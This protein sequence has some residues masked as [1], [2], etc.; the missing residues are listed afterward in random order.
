M[1]ELEK[2]AAFGA[3]SEGDMADEL[4]KLA[5]LHSDG[6]LSDDEFK[7]LKTRVIAGT[8]TSSNDG[9]KEAKSSDRT[10]ANDFANDT[11]P[12][13]LYETVLERFVGERSLAYYE[14]VFAKLIDAYEIKNVRLSDFD[15]RRLRQI[16]LQRDAKIAWSER[17]PFVK[18]SVWNWSAF[19][20]GIFWAVWRGIAYKWWIFA[21]VIVAVVIFDILGSYWWLFGLVI[22]ALLGA[23]G[24]ALFLSQVLQELKNGEVRAQ[25]SFPRQLA[26]SSIAVVIL[27]VGLQII[28]YS[29][30]QDDSGAQNVES[31][32]AASTTS[33]PAQ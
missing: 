5:K 22:A 30:L 23:N 17:L 28:A 7:V 16:A 15:E 29:G 9:A 8:S 2:R 3:G 14:G 19:F 18:D 26:M 21:A 20:F 1:L 33:T 12:I 4:A 27:L 11:V 13:V 6:A 32:G 25:P 31:N 24:N 10:R